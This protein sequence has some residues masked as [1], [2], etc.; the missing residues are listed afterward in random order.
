MTDTAQ[1]DWRPMDTC[2]ENTSVLFWIGHVVTGRMKRNV[3][4]AGG[5]RQDY[6]WGGVFDA[7]PTHWMP[8]PA[9]PK[10]QTL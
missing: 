7:I 3:L 2:P 9:P 10:E 4:R 1:T 6:F 8:L 5:Y